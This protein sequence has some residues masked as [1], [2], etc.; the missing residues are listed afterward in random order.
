MSHNP[1]TA[2]AARPRHPSAFE[3]LT[4][5]VTVLLSGLGAVIGIVLI[6]S[7][8]VACNTAVIG[9]LVAMLLGRIPVAALSGMRD[10]HRQN[11]VQSAVSGAT[12]G[13]ANSL[14]LPISVPFLLGRSDLVWPMLGGAVI[15]LAVD[16]WVLYRVFDSRLLPA[17]GAWPPGV[18]A[19]QTIE[20]GDQGGRKAKV[21]GIGAVAGVAG[22][23]YGL[24][25][26]AAGVAFLGNAW[27]LGMFGLGLLIAQYAPALTH[28]D[29][30][31]A[32]IPHGLMIGAGTVALIQALLLL[33]TRPDP[34]PAADT[35]HDSNGTDSRQAPPGHTFSPD[36]RTVTEKRLRRGFTEGLALFTAGAALVALL[37]GI[38]TRMPPIAVAG[39]I[40]LAGVAALVHQLIVG[41]AAMHSGWFPAFA[42]TLIFLL[43]GLLLHLPPLALALLVGYVAA[44]GP[45]FADMGYDLKAGWLL[46]ADTRPWL[47][48][49]QAGRR[50]QYL[51]QL[52]GFAIALTAVALL[53]QP[54]FSQGRLPPL[55]KVY[56]ATIDTGLGDSTDL[57]R[58]FL[59]AIPGAAIQLIGGT[60]RQ[61]G[62]LLATGLLVAAPHAGWLVLAALT[63]RAAHHTLTRRTGKTAETG[64]ETL[65][66]LGAGLIAGSSLHDITRV[67][68]AL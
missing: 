6:T 40:L 67:R 5:V 68:D 13:A 64:D 26:S 42:V 66:L 23:L 62:V 1:G 11:L 10:R 29:L 17:S 53:W 14:I 63:V 12:F 56:T 47:P 9:A 57:L 61:M 21:L 16:S 48:C 22:S 7:L 2:T 33:R 45:A 36:V 41:L 28:T 58:M 15:G 38:T 37:G 8:G 3:P 44:T 60:G 50:Q 27:A 55:A 25:M 35:R 19:A 39:W 4:L 52:I 65:V 54:L 43:L 31:A 34:G 59:W 51:S 20:A 32:Y 49:E 46:R 24:P 18:A 30:Y